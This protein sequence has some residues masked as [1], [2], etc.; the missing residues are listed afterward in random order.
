MKTVLH[1]LLFAL[2]LCADCGTTQS[3]Q[4]EE[5]IVTAQRREQNL[6]EVPVSA[7]VFSGIEIDR[8]NIRSAAEYLA[9]TPNVSF[10]EDGQAGARG[11]GIAIRG[12][13]NLVSGENAVINSVGI[14]FDDFSVASTPAQVA[15]PFLLD[16]ERIEILRGPQGTYFGRNSLGGVISVTSRTP[17]DQLGGR[18]I[19]G[20]EN[21]EHAGEQYNITGI[22]NMPVS[23]NL[24]LR[25]VAYYENSSG[26]VENICATGASAERCSIAAANSYVPNGSKDSGHDYY[27]GRI[28]V[29]WAP[30]DSTFIGG[31]LMYSDQDQGHDENI[32]SGIIDLDTLN[33]FGLG[34]ATDPR[35]GYWPDNRNQLSH[36]RPEKN[37]LQTWLAILKLQ[38][39]L[40]G[41]KVL[42]WISGVQDAR[43]KRL[44]DNDLV[45][46]A[47]N[48]VRNNNYDGTSWSS[49]L[50]LD[51]T[52]DRVDWTVGVLY[53]DDDQKQKND[54]FTGVGPSAGH[55]LDPPMGVFVLPGFAPG[56][57]LG[58]N[59][60]RFKLESMA[61]F[62]DTT[63]RLTERL[64]LIAGGRYTRDWVENDLQAFGVRPTCCFPFSPDYPGPPGPEFF[65]SF[66]NVLN[67]AANDKQTFD[68][69]SPRAGLRYQI[70]EGASVYTLASKGYKAGGTSL[71]NSPEI[72]DPAYAGP[73]DQETLWNYELGLKSEW[74]ERRLRVNAALFYLDW[75]DMQFESFRA[76]RAGPAAPVVEQTINIGG[77]HSV[78]G[79][80]ELLLVPGENL[81]LST[82]IGYQDSQIDSSE[83]VILTGDY[84]VDLEGLETPKAPKW[85]VSA[86]AEYRTQLGAGEGWLRLE[87]IYREGQYSD[88]EAVANQ[89]TLGPA[90]A[91]G[92]SR[93][94]GPNEFPYRT[95]DYDLF[96]L[97]AGFDTS[98]WNLVLYVQNLTDEKYYTGTQANFGASGI[99]L[100]P[101][102][103]VF[104]FS[105]AYNF[106]GI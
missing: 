23:D 6:Q 1:R 15:N 66:I 12:V 5:V 60:K 105:L 103:R 61:A 106:G 67:P 92:L 75:D 11:L 89:Q 64:E 85:T 55:D 13:N 33:T 53:A 70:S 30:R 39:D 90:P 21:Y 93:P 46:G 24:A 71:G 88:I 18:I 99:R 29:A 100:R 40:G 50:R 31:T 63:I 79:E 97:R 101:H 28:K 69:F 57:G 87:Y 76:L 54:V 42:K 86:I 95:P 16:M 26:L 84:E 44:F 56:L 14:Y 49:E 45:G 20:G 104:G 82:G 102:P 68:D 22:A 36:D 59:Q 8:A 43:L 9:L 41:D 81:T 32:P 96:N 10:T 4:L 78:G 62:A 19:L 47:D 52:G 37:K 74:L 72:G 48:V 83:T 73:F 98:S 25:A 27:M 2:L 80:L 77:A 3:A 91:T 34:E 94:I 35:T 65:A 38:Q 7:T 51:T 58:Q 17:D